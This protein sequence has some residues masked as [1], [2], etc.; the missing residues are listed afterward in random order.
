M[1]H[2]VRMASCLTLLLLLSVRPVAADTAK[3]PPPGQVDFL[4]RLLQFLGIQR[5]P[6]LDT[7]RGSAPA[8]V[9]GESTIWIMK[10][11]GTQPKKLGAPADYRW[12]VF[13]P[14]GKSVA[15][16]NKDRIEVISEAGVSTPLVLA[17]NSAPPER[18]VSWTN[19]GIGFFDASGQVVLVQPSTLDIARGAKASLAELESAM[20]AA[21]TCGGASL[22]EVELVDPDS[23]A[24]RFDVIVR[25]QKKLPNGNLTWEGKNLTSK[26]QTRRNAQ[27]A[28]SA[29]CKRI[30]YIR[31]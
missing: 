14:N 10:S 21:R 5:P 16:I 7:F 15:A 27:P 28:F 31:N 29:D 20:Q 24:A 19:T 18:L 3:A 30:V 17:S 13:S 1:Y 6:A 12:P 8:R 2:R 23:G 25:K 4:T 11:D 26:L 9:V 22:S